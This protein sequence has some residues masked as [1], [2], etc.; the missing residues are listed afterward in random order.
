[1]T[2]SDE[3]Q[4]F[5][6]VLMSQK[7]H[8][9]LRRLSF[10]RRCSVG[11]LIRELLAEGLERMAEHAPVQLEGW[12]TKQRCSCGEGDFATRQELDKHIAE[13]NGDG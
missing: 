8:D 4:V 11:D 12:E 10:A 3:T 9:E 7:M 1:M 6:T 2:T 13:V 5:R